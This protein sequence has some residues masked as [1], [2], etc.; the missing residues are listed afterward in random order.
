MKIKSIIEEKLI[1]ISNVKISV[2]TRVTPRAL[3]V[4]KNSKGFE[5]ETYSFFTHRKEGLLYT[6][7]F[8]GHVNVTGIKHKK[9]IDRLTTYLFDVVNISKIYKIT[10]DNS[11]V[12]GKLKRRL[13][14]KNES[15]T[16][17][18]RRISNSSD[19]IFNKITY[20]RQSFPGVFLKIN[21][22]GTV[23][24]FSSGKFNIVGCKNCHNLIYIL[25]QFLQV[26]SN[27]KITAA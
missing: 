25:N 11:T 15:F 22:V 14:N 13:F 1:V 19:N 3:Q 20:Q 5:K 4:F 18:I 9:D 2:K 10:I 12:T 7:Y 26:M 8:G 23:V 27:N 24:F 17:C 16:E 6:F 21:S